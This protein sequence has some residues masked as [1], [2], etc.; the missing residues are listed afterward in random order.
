VGLHKNKKKLIST[1]TTRAKRGIQCDKSQIRG[2]KKRVRSTEE[3]WQKNDRY[4]G[5][6]GKERNP[7]GYVSNKGAGGTTIFLLLQSYTLA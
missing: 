2:A 3:K 6:Q 4:H 1:T 7:M 5:D